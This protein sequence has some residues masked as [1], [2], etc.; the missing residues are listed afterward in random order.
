MAARTIGGLVRPRQWE[1]A[2]PVNGG[3][4]FN[5]PGNS[6]MTAFTIRAGRIFMNVGVAGS[7]FAFG[8]LKDKICMAKPAADFTVTAL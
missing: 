4:I 2:L 6:V 5:N 7:T 8:F 1:A 3:C